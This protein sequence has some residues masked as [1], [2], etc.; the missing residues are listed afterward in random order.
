MTLSSL[1]H[2]GS[3]MLS[4]SSRISSLTV[5]VVDDR[6]RTAPRL[7]GLTVD[8]RIDSYERWVMVPTQEL[9]SA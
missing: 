9:G 7:E 4:R 3:L 1:R 6:V 8:T 2:H 5:L